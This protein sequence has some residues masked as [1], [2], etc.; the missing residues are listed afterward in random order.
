MKH[1]QKSVVDRHAD[2]FVFKIISDT[3]LKKE[4]KI[5]K[6]KKEKKTEKKYLR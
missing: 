2:A 6:L 3:K 5:K 4:K 1:L